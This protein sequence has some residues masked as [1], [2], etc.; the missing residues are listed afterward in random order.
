[1]A[2]KKVAPTVRRRGLVIGR[3][4][5]LALAAIGILV[6]INTRSAQPQGKVEIE[7]RGIQ[8]G[9]TEEGFPYLGSL[10]APVVLIEFTDF[11]CSHCQAYNLEV[12][13]SILRDYVATGKVRYV[14]HYYS[15]TSPRSLQA[16][17]AT[18]CAAEQGIYFQF[19]H[20]LFENPAAMREDFIARARE[21]GLDADKFA[22]CWDAGRYRNALMGHIQAARK[23]G[24]SATP[25][26]KINDQLV[27]GNMPHMIRQ[28]IE[29]EL[30][31]AGQ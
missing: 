7:Y 19:Q 21:V 20:A 30:A 15:N 16:A 14:S 26:F 17:E 5:V 11:N 4:A 9:F 18:M 3:I 23:M 29:D 28:T 12:E 2:K 1:M 24:V 31:V 8:G 13:E 22:A 6:L 25:S 10:E 27:V